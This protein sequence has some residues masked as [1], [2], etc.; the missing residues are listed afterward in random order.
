MCVV[1]QVHVTVLTSYARI[2]FRLEISH[3]ASQFRDPF[4]DS[5]TWIM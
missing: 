5:V 4:S 1:M 3:G 2:H